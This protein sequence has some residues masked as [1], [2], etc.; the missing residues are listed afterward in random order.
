MDMK[1]SKNEGYLIVITVIAVMLAAIGAW[2][3]L[4]W[5]VRFFFPNLF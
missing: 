5:I 2:Y 1:N 4:E 3:L